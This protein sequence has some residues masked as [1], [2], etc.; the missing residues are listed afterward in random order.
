MWLWCANML[1][2]RLKQRG[3][4]KEFG[5]GDVRLW[6]APAY[7]LGILAVRQGNPSTLRSLGELL[8]A[9]RLLT[10]LC[11]CRLSLD[12]VLSPR[13]H[14][15]SLEMPCSTF[16]TSSQPQQVVN[17]AAP[18]V[19]FCHV[20]SADCSQSRDMLPMLSARADKFDHLVAFAEYEATPEP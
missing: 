9:K 12:L 10:Q 13:P 7:L 16:Q 14:V 2:S 11:V 20:L 4:C 5:A 19:L 3:S 17:C 1:G 8:E 6:G 18:L 15:Y